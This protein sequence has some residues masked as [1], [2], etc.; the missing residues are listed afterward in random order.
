MNFP[1]IVS[2]IVK[3]NLALLQSDYDRLSNTPS[4][5]KLPLFTNKDLNQLINAVI[6]VL[7]NDP[8]VLDLFT[9]IIVVG[10]I[11]GSIFDLYKII[12][13]FGLPPTRSY[14]FLGDFIDGGQF[15][16]ETITFL[17]ALKVVYP[18]NIYLLC[19]PH[20]IEAV[21]HTRQLFKEIQQID[22]SGSL[23][24]NFVES[25]KHLPLAAL[26]FST[27]FCSAGGITSDFQ[28]I[29][30]LMD[31]PKPFP[32]DRLSQINQF[33]R[34][35]ANSSCI[36]F[37]HNNKKCLFG[38]YSFDKFMQ[39]NRL[40]L[41]ITGNL[42]SMDGIKYLFGNKLCSIFSISNF[43]NK[44]NHCGVL[45]IFGSDDY[46]PIKLPV[47]PFIPRNSVTFTQC[48]AQDIKPK[49]QLQT[50]ALPKIVVGA[51]TS[52]RTAM[53]ILET[54]KDSIPF[55]HPILT[56]CN[57]GDKLSKISRIRTFGTSRCPPIKLDTFY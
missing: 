43:K 47:L 29:Q 52:R 2:Q 51:S 20:E 48:N 26:L 55:G 1:Q 50:L 9:P 40:N 8:V 5:L 37:M 54:S 7:D 38:Q 6:P 15:S 42:F 30:D 4:D 36:G 34:S 39:Q 23:Y 56:I 14:L 21:S 18:R 10:S 11:R 27:I 31:V 25:F 33:L 17:Y 44:L 49:Q 35:E 12:Q 53:R 32:N 46:K 45:A 41:L 22:Q 19:G 16:L 13:R 57:G 24:Q 28:L 3:A